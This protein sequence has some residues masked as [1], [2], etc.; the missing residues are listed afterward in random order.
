MFEG[1]NE[2]E[3]A[4]ED[5]ILVSYSLNVDGILDISAQERVTGKQISGRI[6]DALGARTDDTVVR[7][8]P[9]TAQ[10]KRLGTRTSS[11]WKRPRPR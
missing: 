4:Y 7:L 9:G 2:N 11:C 5:G 8:G 3:N 10:S 1:L 6:E